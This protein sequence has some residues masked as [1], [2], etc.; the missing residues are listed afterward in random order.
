MAG[1]W[2]EQ[3]LAA[4]SYPLDRVPGSAHVEVLAVTSDRGVNRRLAQLGIVVGAAL[5]VLRSAPM[6]GA[7]LVEVQ[8]STVALGRG[9]ARR[10]SVRVLA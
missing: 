3:Q 7:I 1:D 8:G 10:V 6:G 4:N 5:R 2:T 9:L